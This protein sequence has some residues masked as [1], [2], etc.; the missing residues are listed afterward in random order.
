MSESVPAEVEAPVLDNEPGPSQVAAV[1]YKR[2]KKRPFYY[3]DPQVVL[4]ASHTIIPFL[5]TL[6]TIPLQVDEQTYKIHR[7]F[8]TRESRY[9]KNLFSLPQPRDFISVEGS[10]NNPI[11]IPETDT[12]EFEN[13]LR[14]FYFGYETCYRI[15]S[16]G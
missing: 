15:C 2:P 8:L 9:F 1:E 12:N 4:Q 3:D 16:N 5:L 13:L 7:H 6:F 10:D 11:K 14:F